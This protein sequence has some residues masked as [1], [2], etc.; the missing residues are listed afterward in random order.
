MGR[1]QH[2]HLFP[3]FVKGLLL[4]SWGRI[5]MAGGRVTDMKTTECA[6]NLRMLLS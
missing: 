2:F 3:T 5:S 4:P 6:K 1:F